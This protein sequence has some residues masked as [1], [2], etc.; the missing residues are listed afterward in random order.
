MI[1]KEQCTRKKMKTL[2]VTGDLLIKTKIQQQHLEPFVPPYNAIIGDVINNLSRPSSCVKNSELGSS[3][4]NQVPHARHFN[5]TAFNSCAAG[6]TANGAGLRMCL[7]RKEEKVSSRSSVMFI[8]ISASNSLIYKMNK[9]LEMNVE[10]WRRNH[11]QNKVI[12]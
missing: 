6:R 1:N 8:H 7:P 3:S 2:F 10:D 11:L 5:A 12:N 9:S 4:R